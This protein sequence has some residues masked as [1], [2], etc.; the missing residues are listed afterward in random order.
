MR[1]LAVV[2]AAVLAL[3]G[4]APL[5]PAAW[6]GHA[7]GSIVVIAKL[8]DFKWEAHGTE[9]P[10]G[11]KVAFGYDLFDTNLQRGGDGAG[12]CQVTKADHATH[13][14]SATC[15]AFFNI[16]GGKIVTEGEVTHTAAMGGAVVLNITEGTG[17]YS[18]ATGTATVEPLFASGPHPAGQDDGGMGHDGHSKDH[19]VKVTFDL[20]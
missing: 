11:D 16:E 9:G 1:K 15:H 7:T 2:V 17:T 8:T 20:K 19:L 12:G 13:E 4:T 3:V 6:A 5:M 18:D 10:E 14:F